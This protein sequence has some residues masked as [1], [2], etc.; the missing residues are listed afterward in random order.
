MKAGSIGPPGIYLGAKLSK[1][2]LPNGV[3]AWAMSPSNKYVQEAVK[4]VEESLERE[5][6]HGRKLVRKAAT[7]FKSNY[8]P[9]LDISPKLSPEAGSYYQSQIGTILQWALE[10]G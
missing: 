6:H 4:N 1:V 3:E 5:Y 2:R 7:P 9:E 8:Q 10:L